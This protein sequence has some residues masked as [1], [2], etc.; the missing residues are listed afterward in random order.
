MECDFILNKDNMDYA[1]IQVCMTI[2]GSRETEDREYRPFE[3]I[4]DNYPKYRVTRSDL[5]QRRDGVKHV[6]I[7]PFMKENKLFD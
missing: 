6:N 7:G 3:K 5:I 1:Y 4:R 2:M